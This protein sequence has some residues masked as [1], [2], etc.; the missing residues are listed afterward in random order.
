MAVL[1][2]VL[3]GLCIPA[4]AAVTQDPQKSSAPSVAGASD[5]HGDECKGKPWSHGGF[6]KNKCKQ[7]PPGPSW[8][9]RPSRSAG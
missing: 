5:R 4:V 6:G 9:T 3:A 7:G 2:L 1:T 8:S